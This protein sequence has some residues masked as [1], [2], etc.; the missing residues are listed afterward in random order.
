MSA[1]MDRRLSELSLGAKHPDIELDTSALVRHAC[2]RLFQQAHQEI[3]IVSRHLDGAL[4]NNASVS[5]ALKD[6]VLR[7]RNT[8]VRVLCKD[9]MPAVK[10]NHRL[11]ELAY[12]LSSFIEIRTPTPEYR[13]HNAAYVVA[14]GLGVV[15]RT[16]ADRYEATVSFAHHAFAGELVREFNGMW[17]SALPSPALRRLHLWSWSS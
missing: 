9:P 14:D 13:E 10:E 11:I 6:F 7:N 17:A 16:Q 2:L 15:H 1:T 4:F 3:L 8:H 5:T 12:R